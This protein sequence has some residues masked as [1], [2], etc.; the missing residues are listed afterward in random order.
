MNELNPHNALLEYISPDIKQESGW[1]NTEHDEFEFPFQWIGLTASISVDIKA[2]SKFLYIYAG[3]PEFSG[4]RNISIS[5]SDVEQHLQILPGWHA[6]QFNIQSCKTDHHK[7][8]RFTLNIDQMLDVKEDP[9]ELGIMVRDL[10]CLERHAD[11]VEWREQSG[12]RNIHRRIKFYSSNNTPDILWLASFPRSGNTWMRFLLTNLLFEPVEESNMIGEY[13][14]EIIDP[15]YNLRQ[16]SN[17]ET[18]IFS[19]KPAH[20]LKTH[21]PFSLSM[22]LIE[23]TI[24]AIYVLRNPLDIAVS[25]RKQ[26]Y[27]KP[28]EYQQ[29]FL[30]YGIDTAL[31]LRNYGNWHSHVFS[32]LEVAKTAH[33]IPV[34]L[35]KY[36]D[37]VTDPYTS[38]LK[39]LNWLQIERSSTHIN[40]AIEL[41]SI[42]NLR[43]MESN[44]I[45]KGKPGIFFSLEQQQAIKEGW[46]F[47]ADAKKNNYN[48]YLDEAEIQLGQS[49]FGPL[50]KK[51]NYI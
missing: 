36:E 11:K 35:I 49:T 6:Y 3:S 8:A 9:R 13:I 50:M 32:W 26:Y 10:H 43:K 33:S 17:R 24:G 42:N 47:L 19:N 12:R 39:I 16:S 18:T 37:L 15:L 28:K 38:C 2:D 45:T 44:E 23:K 34:L 20:I 22:P 4:T 51:F 14:D 31:Q 1:G 46:R 29:H 27:D 30:T 25:L 7:Q 21:M 41:S 40:Q 48:N 5:G